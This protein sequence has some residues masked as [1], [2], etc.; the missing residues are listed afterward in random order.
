[1]IVVLGLWVLIITAGLIGGLVLA[2][3]MMMDDGAAT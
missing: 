2:K 1:M 3:I